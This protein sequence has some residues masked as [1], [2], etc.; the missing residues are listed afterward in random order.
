MSTRGWNQAEL[1]KKQGKKKP[2]VTLLIRQNP[3]KNPAA[4][5]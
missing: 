5:H 3:I 1:M 2:S 4:T